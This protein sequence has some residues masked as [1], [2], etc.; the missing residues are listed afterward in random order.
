MVNDKYIRD[1]TAKALEQKLGYCRDDNCKP[2]SDNKYSKQDHSFTYTCVNPAFG[3]GLQGF[4]VIQQ[5]T[6]FRL[7]QIKV[8]CNS[9]VDLIN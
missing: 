7:S 8:D 4:Q 3:E 6:P 5:I 9:A 1:F 2:V